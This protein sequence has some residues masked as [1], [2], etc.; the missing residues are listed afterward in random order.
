MKE[1]YTAAELADLKLPCMPVTARGWNEIAEREGW[2]TRTNR[3]GALLYRRR[4]GRGGGFEYHVSL[5]PVTA[6][7]TISIRHVKAADAPPLEAL[8]DG[9]GEMPEP[10]HNE[11]GELRRDAALLILN[12]WDIFRTKFTGPLETA[13]HHFAA[14]YNN[15]K[16]DGIP[17]WVR[18]ARPQF[19]VNTLRNW[20][21]KRNHS[22]FT[23]LAGQYGNR[24]GS[25]VLNQAEDG[26][27]EQF[28]A[29]LIVNQPHLTADHLHD[30][31]AA[32]FGVDLNVNGK[33]KPLPS[34]RAFQRFVSTWK[35]EHQEA[36]LKITDPDEFKNKF[37]FTGS[38]MNHWVRRP[39]QLWEIDASPADVLLKDGRYSI[40][41][42][43]DI[44]TRRMLVTVTKTPKT[45]A[46]LLLMRVAIQAWGV[47][48]I[49]R[50]DNGSDFVSYAF[51]RALSA[52][53]IHQ[54]ITAPFSPEQKGTVERHIGTLQRG[55][56]PLLPGFVGHNVTD[57]KK[58]EARK[59]FAQRLGE[60]DK[61]A[62]CVELDHEELQEAV[63][64][65]VELKYSHKPHDG[66][67]G[68]TPFEM[69]ATWTGPV[70]QIENE[71]AL[72][73]LLSPVAGKDGMR[74]V[75]K[76]GIALDRAK[77]IHPNLIPGTQVL[78]RHDPDDMGR[79]YVF[80]ANGRDFICV[81]QCPERVGINPGDAVRAVRAE[82]DRR[83]KEEVDP[84]KRAI[85][86]MKPLDMIDGVLRANNHKNGSLTSF[87]LRGE[88]HTT[89]D[90]EAATAAVPGQRP[91]VP[92]SE[93]QEAVH[94]RVVESL[95]E[96]RPPE[97]SKTPEARYARA[98]TI[99][100]AMAADK[101]VPLEDQMWLKNYWTT[102]EFNSRRRL[103]KSFAGWALGTDG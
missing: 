65:W 80:S 30:L 34:I 60:T 32:E 35:D 4:K 44:Y 93:R 45:A 82:Q 57:R 87:P 24:K 94:A 2:K 61:N 70:R 86:S 19:S 72:D 25:G 76:H 3:A 54:D 68:K 11:A 81:A 59:S 98:C 88:R 5:L 49:L 27:V 7:N 85:K 37:K 33:L 31:V 12:F 73:I 55:L 40:Y 20:E 22:Q 51:K 36:L 23:Q 91:D 100:E 62:F 95:A 10:T 16:I 96:H 53:G 74:T 17:D 97:P 14:M 28:I 1:W 89:P 46:V 56:M 8:W 52:L 101:D 42:V 39:N 63:N 92:L 15:N 67:G 13:R 64:R 21:T 18:A 26:K 102:A 41:A 77:F 90:L 6:R 43:V 84:L 79:I 83:L 38:N 66:L 58:I 50:T 29:A 99:E 71:R 78:C 48:E 103:D 47:P 9:V 75:T 69:V